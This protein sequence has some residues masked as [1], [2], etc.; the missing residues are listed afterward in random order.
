MAFADEYET[1]E[2]VRGISIQEALFGV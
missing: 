2:I 1:K